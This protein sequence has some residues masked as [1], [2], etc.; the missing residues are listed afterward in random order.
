MSAASTQVGVA[1]G[2]EHP[3]A[4]RS[5]LVEA[6]LH[7][8]RRRARGRARAARTQR[9]PHAIAA[10]SDGRR[11]RP[12]PR[13]VMVG[14]AEASRSI[15]MVDVI[16]RRMRVRRRWSRFSGRKC[17]ALGVLRPA[18]PTW[19]PNS[20][21]RSATRLVEPRSA[22]PARR[23]A[24]SRRRACRFKPSDDGAEVVGVVMRLTLRLSTSRVSPPV[25]GNTASSGSSGSE[26]VDEP[27]SISHHDVV[28]WPARARSRRPP[29]CR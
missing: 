15:S 16:G 17:Y 20:A 27:S 26:T 5:D 13:I 1:G 28:A 2:L 14:G 7:D 10:A 24:A 4:R 18:G 22:A 6:Q 23:S 21:A 12:A 19:Q 3:G 25:P 8:R 11:S 9:P 29:R